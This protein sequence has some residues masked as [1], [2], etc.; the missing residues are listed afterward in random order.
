MMNSS[1]N[2]RRSIIMYNLKYLMSPKSFSEA[3]ENYNTVII[4]YLFMLGHK[5]TEPQFS[6]V[7][8]K[9][10]DRKNFG[11]E[12]LLGLVPDAEYE[13]IEK[14]PEE[15]RQD[16][17]EKCWPTALSYIVYMGGEIVRQLCWSELKKREENHPDIL[18]PA[19][20]R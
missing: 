17:R 19:C 15:D 10:D 18:H 3:R 16:S 11:S 5:E 20:L 8:P 14:K 6:L 12:K 1:D 13:D 9:R 2:S 7:L 4:L